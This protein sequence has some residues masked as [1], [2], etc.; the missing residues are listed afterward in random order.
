MRIRLFEKGGNSAVSIELDLRTE[1]T[2]VLA[3]HV[4]RAILTSLLRSS[5]YRANEYDDE[6]I[7][8]VLPIE[9]KALELAERA[10][11]DTIQNSSIEFYRELSIEIGMNL[12]D[13]SRL[14]AA[15]EQSEIRLSRL[16]DSDSLNGRIAALWDVADLSRTESLVLG[17]MELLDRSFVL[18]REIRRLL[19]VPEDDFIYPNDFIPIP[20]FINMLE[21]ESSIALACRDLQRIDELLEIYKLVASCSTDQLDISCP[22]WSSRAIFAL[23]Y[24]RGAWSISDLSGL[25]SAAYIVDNW[26]RIVGYRGRTQFWADPMTHANRLLRARL[27]IGSNA[28]F[29]PFSDALSNILTSPEIIPNEN[30]CP[31]LIRLMTLPIKPA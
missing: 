11:S 5:S 20:A 3:P 9:S 19:E 22:L 1:W 29:P 14:T 4:E 30:A 10:S 21:I 2:T 27:R 26:A 17:D 7:R 16:S 13:A 18:S 23:R 6:F 28:N 12:G 25:H 31:N 24:G 8:R 15:R